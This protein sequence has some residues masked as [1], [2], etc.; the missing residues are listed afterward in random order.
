MDGARGPRPLLHHPV[1]IRRD[2]P[3]AARDVAK[4]SDGCESLIKSP[5][6]GRKGKQAGTRELVFFSLAIYRGS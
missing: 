6:R 1:H 3:A 5:Y 4:P 2:N